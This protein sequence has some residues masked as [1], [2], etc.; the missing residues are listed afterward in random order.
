MLEQ[1]KP[2]LQISLLGFYLWNNIEIF[3]YIYIYIFFL[4]ILSENDRI[5]SKIGPA[6]I[7]HFYKLMAFVHFPYLCAGNI[8]PLI[9]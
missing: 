2:F 8:A 9:L 5:F 7:N 4:G 3:K 6:E 1:D